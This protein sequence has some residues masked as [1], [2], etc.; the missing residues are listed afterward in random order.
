MRQIR[1][2]IKR[3]PPPRYTIR[4]RLTR[5]E[6]RRLDAA[7]KEWAPRHGL[8][9]RTARATYVRAAIE[10]FRDRPRQ[11]RDRMALGAFM[12]AERDTVTIAIGFPDAD[13]K[14]MVEARARTWAREC[15]V[16]EEGCV[17]LYV[18]ERARNARLDADTIYV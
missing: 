9:P 3:R 1:V 18:R 7:V 11:P 17:S 13:G 14:A 6:K 4:V 5:D 2:V 15:G 10:R 16:A 12:R 8:Q